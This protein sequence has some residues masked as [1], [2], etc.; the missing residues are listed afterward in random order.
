E[1]RG[2]REAFTGRATDLRSGERPVEIICDKQIEFPVAIIVEP[3]SGNSPEFLPGGESPAHPSSFGYI[4]ERAVSVVVI[5][6]IAVEAGDVKIRMAVVVVIRSRRTHTVA[7][8]THPRAIRHVHEC[9]IVIIAIEPI[10][11]LALVLHQVRKMSAVGEENVEV[12]VT[13][14]V[15]QR[16]TARDPVNHRLVGKSAIVENE[17]DSGSRLPVF[18]LN[19]VRFRS[20]HAG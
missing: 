7:L 12:S 19:V 11:K 13:I 9:S 3:G 8:S 20:P 2:T 17:I 18:E 16:H 10:G 14:I 1:G 4:A 6:K 15:Q 5:E